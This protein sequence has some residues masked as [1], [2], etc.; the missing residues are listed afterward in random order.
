VSATHFGAKV[1][2]FGLAE[3]PESGSRRQAESN[4]TLT[5]AV[6]RTYEYIAPEQKPG[7]PVD[8]RADV[9]A[10]GVMLY[11]LLTGAPARGAYTPPSR[12]AQI[13]VR[14][15]KNVLHL[16]EGIRGM[17]LEWHCG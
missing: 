3:A 7:Q 5:R 14:L 2:D 16:S 12:K 4:L 10:L 13:D 9:Y 15:D 17:V 11:E 6:L 8:H 1:A